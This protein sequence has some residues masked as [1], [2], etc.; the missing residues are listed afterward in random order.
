VMGLLP[1]LVGMSNRMA[2]HP[3]IV[4]LHRYEH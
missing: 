1:V 4:K 3:F 2:H